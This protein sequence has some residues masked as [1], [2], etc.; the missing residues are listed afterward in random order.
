MGHLQLQSKALSIL[1][2]GIV[3]GIMNMGHGCDVTLLGLVWLV[4]LVWFGHFAPLKVSRLVHF[5]L[6]PLQLL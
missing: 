4:G 5:Q 3:V 2:P 6:P 1:L